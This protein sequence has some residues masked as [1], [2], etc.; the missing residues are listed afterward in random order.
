MLLSIVSLLK[1]IQMLG[2]CYIETDLHVSSHQNKLGKIINNTK[3]VDGTVSTIW[4]HF[5]NLK[6]VKNTY[7]GV[8]LLVTK[9]LLLREC[10]SCF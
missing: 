4:Y 7:G 1:I 5:H 8:I 3:D 2:K 6:N 10:F 9:V